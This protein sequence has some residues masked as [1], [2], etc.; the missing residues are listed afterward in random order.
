MKSIFPL[1]GVLF[2]TSTNAQKFDCSAETTIYQDYFKV[3]NISEAFNGWSEVRKNCPKTETVYTDGIQILQYKIDNAKEDEKETLV[4]DLMKT[5]HTAT[6]LEVSVDI[7]RRTYHTGL[8][9][10]AAMKD[11]LQ[12]LCDDHLGAWNYR[13]FPNPT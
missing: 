9:A 3:K 6:G 7:L 10:S 8:K 2:I 5:A 12:L 11:Q 13:M 1:I 4:R